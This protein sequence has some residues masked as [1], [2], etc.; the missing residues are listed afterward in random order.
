MNR[1]LKAL[2]IRK[3]VK[4][5]MIAKRANVARSTVS[6]VLGG[7]QQSLPVKRAT[8]ELLNISLDRLEKLWTRKAA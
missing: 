3:G 1:Q 4:Q 7:H 6:V 8:A 5:T 2:L